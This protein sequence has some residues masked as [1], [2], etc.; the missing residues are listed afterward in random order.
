MLEQEEAGS[1]ALAGTYAHETRLAV[2]SLILGDTTAALDW[3]DRAV[4]AGYRDVRML[5]TV[6]TLEALRPHPR[7][8]RLVGRLEDL[9]RRERDRLD[10]RTPL[11]S[12]TS[13]GP[14]RRS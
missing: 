13:R 12:W 8:R 11:E 2:A 4:D 5:Q 14:D 7:F 1:A 6:P 10:A 9:L 3:L